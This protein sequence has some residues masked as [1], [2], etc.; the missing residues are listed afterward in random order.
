VDLAG[1]DVEV[2]AGEDHLRAEGPADSGHLDEGAGH[3][4]D[5]TALVDRAR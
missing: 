3:G 4:R 2:D 5:R 1:P